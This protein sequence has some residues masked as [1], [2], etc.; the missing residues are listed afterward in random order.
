[1]ITEL[2]KSNK[3]LEEALKK[4]EEFLKEKPELI[5][6]QQ[7]I[8]DVMSKAGKKIENREAALRGLIRT[9]LNE[10]VEKSQK[11]QELTKNISGLEK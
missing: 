9:T 3:E 8:D 5:E 2:R 7:V 4:R 10:L 6:F 11:I 1:M